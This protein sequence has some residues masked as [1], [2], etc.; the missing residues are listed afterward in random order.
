MVSWINGGV[1]KDARGRQEAL[2]GRS[3][4]KLGVRNIESLVLEGIREGD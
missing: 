2:V 1:T 3:A 4:G